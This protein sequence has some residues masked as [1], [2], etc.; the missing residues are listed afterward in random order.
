MNKGLRGFPTR[1]SL[2]SVGTGATANNLDG[3]PYSPAEGVAYM[4]PSDDVLRGDL[5]ASSPGRNCFPLRPG[6]LPSGGVA[7]SAIEPAADVMAATSVVSVSGSGLVSGGVCVGYA[8]DVISAGTGVTIE[9]GSFALNDACLLASG[10]YIV[11]Y[12]GAPSFKR[13][14]AAGVLQSTSDGTSA[15]SISSLAVAALA[16]GGFVGAWGSTSSPSV[17]FRRYNATGVL[18]GSEVVVE[19]ITTSRCAVAGLTGGS[20][21]VAYVTAGAVKFA[22]YDAGGTII[23]SA[24]SVEADASVAVEKSLSVVALSGGGF[25]VVWSST[26]A[27]GSIRFARY[28][29]VGAL[30]GSATQASTVAFAGWMEAAATNAGG[31]A[32]AFKDGSSVNSLMIFNASGVQ[33]GTTTLITTSNTPTGALTNLP[34]GNLVASYMFGTSAFSVKFDAA[35]RIIG[36]F[37]ATGFSSG[38]YLNVCPLADE[39]FNVIGNFSTTNIRRVPATYVGSATYSRFTKGGMRV[40][41][42]ADASAEPSR[43]IAVA[44]LDG[45]GAAVVW[46]TKA[47]IPQVAVASRAGVLSAPSAPETVYARSVSVAALTGGG[48]VVAYEDYFGARVRF[49]R[50]TAAGVANGAAVTVESTT[51]KMVSVD[52]LDTGGFVVAYLN[53]SDHAKFATFTA[54]GAVALAAASAYAS[55]LLF[56]SVAG[57]SAGQFALH[58]GTASTVFVAL[59]SAAGAVTLRNLQA[60]GSGSFVAGSI[61]AVPGDMYALTYSEQGGTNSVK[62]A[63]ISSDNELVVAP[64]QVEA[65]ALASV[66]AQAVTS[67]GDTWS[68]YIDGTNVTIGRYASSLVLVGAALDSSSPGGLLPVK[69]SGTATLRL[70][71]GPPQAF[72]HTAAAP[73]QGN[74]GTI[75]GRAAVLKGF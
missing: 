42:I 30:Q 72:D 28:D 27:S 41:L 16:D 47:G 23:G 56:V 34:S 13:F 3:D 46:T 26:L 6:S 22:L 10:E 61:A 65:A 35:G 66:C 36:S 15:V 70:D 39:T 37:E 4:S 50:Y 20:F 29:S 9:A 48:F 11:A 57:S 62:T 38:T 68:I 32:V 2:F 60:A 58:F 53:A 71:W 64:V 59:I 31:F 51:A 12:G 54:A 45:G 74:K 49:R 73:T 67:G 24:V 43:N 63:T 40:G 52:R 7:G 21:V 33:V 25:V 14:T 5:L 18:Q 55:P 8:R 1:E 75:L 19:S 17:R 44:G 69:V